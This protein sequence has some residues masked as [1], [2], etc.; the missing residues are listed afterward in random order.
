M[1]QTRNQLRRQP[2]RRHPPRHPPLPPLR[3][4]HGAGP[5]SRTWIP[6]STVSTRPSPHPSP[7]SPLETPE[8][9]QIELPADLAKR[10]AE[11]KSEQERG[12]VLAEYARTLGAAKQNEKE[13][14][15][16]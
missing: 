1:R 15:F 14:I 2:P 7:Q 16:M 3:K 11:A 9:Q 5:P 13:A 12:T 6:S 10:F 4:P 8:K